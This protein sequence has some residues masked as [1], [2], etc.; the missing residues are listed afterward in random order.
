MASGFPL[1][2]AIRTVKS[3]I[4]TW[5]GFAQYSALDPSITR[6]A[7]ARAVGEA[8]AAIANTLNE[9]VRPL[10]RRPAPGEYTPYTSRRATGF[11]QYVKMFTRDRE[12]GVVSEQWWSYKTDTLRSR[13]S[14]LNTAWQ[15]FEAATLP[16]G[17]FEGEQVIGAE[18]A[19]TV[20]MI[21][22]AL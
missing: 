15:R 21:P 16:E 18:Y 2:A 6:E 14:V 19:G 10:N 11:L 5:Q 7:W 4:G 22:E 12:T 17:T 3:R 8:R 20:Q 9:A 13:Q 1:W